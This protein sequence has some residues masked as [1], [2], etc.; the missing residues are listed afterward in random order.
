[1][2]RCFAPCPLS[3]VC[4]RQPGLHPPAGPRFGD[5]AKSCAVPVDP[6][7]QPNGKI[8]K[9]IHFLDIHHKENKV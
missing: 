6:K 9:Y 3:N 8:M 4:A 2:Y 7:T 1:M 5:L